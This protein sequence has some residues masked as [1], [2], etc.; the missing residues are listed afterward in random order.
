[1]VKVSLSVFPHNRAALALYR[2]FGFSEEGRLQGHTKK[3]TGYEDEIVMA[4]WVE[5]D[6]R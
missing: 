3:S 2:R 4:R 6:P 1:V 5:E